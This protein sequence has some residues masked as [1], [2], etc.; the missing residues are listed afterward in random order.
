MEIWVAGL[1]GAGMMLLLVVLRERSSSKQVQALAEEIRR[2]ED[3]AIQGREM[4]R[5]NRVL[6]L[7]SLGFQMAVWRARNEQSLH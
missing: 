6:V 3:I 5:E 4:A 2:V 1:A 7:R